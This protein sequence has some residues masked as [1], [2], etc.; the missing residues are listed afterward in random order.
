M[1][2]EENKKPYGAVLLK[3]DLILRVLAQSSEDLAMTEIAKRADITLSTT[4]KILDTLLLIGY[5]RRNEDSKRFSLGASLIQF[6]N[7]AFL[8]FE[9]VRESYPALKS[10]FDKF[11]EN[12][13]LGM[14]R[15]NNILYINKI[16]NPHNKFQTLSRI[17]DTQPLYCSAMGKATLA[18]FNEE[19]QKEYLDSVNLLTRTPHTI[20]DRAELLRQVRQAEELDYAIDDRE[21]EEDVYCI[22][23]AINTKGDNNHYAFS[24][25]VPYYRLTEELKKEIIAAVLR[26]KTIIEYQLES[27][28]N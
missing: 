25:S 19:E 3:A 16:N 6:S 11:G 12:V 2:V 8:N 4:S 14:Y 10:L 13:H 22:G 7:A 28:L 9:I 1:V 23:A 20:T 27:Q 5:V 26:S 17:G 24:I 18:N 21:N 15:D